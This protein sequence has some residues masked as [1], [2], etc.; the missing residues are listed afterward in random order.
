MRARSRQTARLDARRAGAALP[1]CDRHA[2]FVAPRD[3]S[4]YAWR[5][6]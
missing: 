1:C 6:S 3:F 4:F 2:A 5:F